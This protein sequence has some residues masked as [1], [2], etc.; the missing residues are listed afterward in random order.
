MDLEN[1]S[2]TDANGGA[3]DLPSGDFLKGKSPMLNISNIC[4][5]LHPEEFVQFF[6]KDC[7]VQNE[8]KVQFCECICAEC[9]VHGEHKGHDVMNVRQAYKEMSGRI[10]DALIRAQ[11]RTE[12]QQ[13]AMLRAQEDRREVE[14]VIEQGKQAIHNE[15]EKLRA[16]LSEKEVQLMQAAEA[17]ERQAAEQLRSKTLDADVHAQTLQECQDQLKTL[18]TRG[19]EV[20]ALNTYAKI[21]RRVLEVLKPLE[22]RT[23]GD[24]E[25]QLE[26]EELK[27]HVQRSLETQVAE[28]A[29]LS[30]R[31]ADI[32]RTGT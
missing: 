11:E 10:S 9:A 8:Q 3:G 31:V 23:L 19:D 2:Y 29:S 5:P 12:A 1:S 4:C 18:D 13:K 15:F 22:G 27:N 30:A 16:A 26:L 21:R 17:T 6:C 14:L 25:V 20:R 28:V 24:N 7:N 32:R